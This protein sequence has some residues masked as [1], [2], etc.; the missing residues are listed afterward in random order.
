MSSGHDS[1]GTTLM[2]LITSDPSAAPAAGASSQQPSSGGGGGSLGR[3]A[4]PPAPAP[5]DR[6]SKRA[7]LMQIQSDT[8]SAAKAFNPV[9][10]LPQRNRKK[11]ARLLRGRVPH[12]YVLR[13]LIHAEFSVSLQPVSYSQ[14]A[15]SIHELAATCDQKK[16][17]RQLVNS[18]F[19]K[20]AVYNSV[21]PSVAPSLLMLHQQCEDRNVLRYVYYYLARILSDNGS[22]GLS[23]AGG[24][25][26]P[27]WDAL[28]DIDVAGGV[29]RADVVPR[30]VDQLSAES[31]SDDVEFMRGDLRL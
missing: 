21:D 14:L 2:D 13:T 8:I 20:L 19:P 12:F 26:T 9:K 1:S 16:S 5:A 6:K 24:I 25:P 15:R 27:N 18:V 22:Q 31:T 17:Q 28:A 29:T 23:A 7:T 10:A 4:P 30:I 11:K 3:P